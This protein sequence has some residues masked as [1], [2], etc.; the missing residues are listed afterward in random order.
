MSE[1][2][3]ASRQNSEENLVFLKARF[4][5]YRKA[6]WIVV[7]QVVL[8]ILIPIVM[9]LSA[10]FFPEFRAHFVLAGIMITLVDLLV[11]DRLLAK[12]IS[13]A[14]KLGEEFDSRVLGI[15]WANVFVGARFS[16]ELLRKYSANFKGRHT[17]RVLNWYPL[18]A[19]SL[20]PD[21][22]ALL[23]QRTNL[24]YDGEL[25]Q[26]YAKLVKISGVGI[27]ASCFIAS[28]A[29]NQTLQSSILYSVAP[30]LPYLSWTIRTYFRQTDVSQAQLRNLASADQLLRLSAKGSLSENK[31]R[32]E[33]RELQN[34]IY[35]RRT[36]S[37]L[38]LPLFYRMLRPRMEDQMANGAEQLI[39]DLK[40]MN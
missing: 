12:P 33:I 39:K 14:A 1:L 6:N 16:P 36:A 28:W 13:E 31:A 5:V 15:S 3:A 34:A 27:F 9:A 21:R 26:N 37:P 19:F 11:I 29:Q 40:L 18:A 10:L 30:L 23:C 20:R 22:T 8:T 2:E 17:Q 4:V 25:R 24:W 32:S 38:M 7:L 35:S